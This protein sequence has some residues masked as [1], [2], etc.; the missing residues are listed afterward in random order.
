MIRIVDAREHYDTRS[1]RRVKQRLRITEKMDAHGNMVLV[2]KEW[3]KGQ[4]VDLTPE[5]IATEGP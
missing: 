4:W 2:K 5:Y 1:E 3:V